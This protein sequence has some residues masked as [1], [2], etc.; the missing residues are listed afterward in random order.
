VNQLS[1]E[2][3]ETQDSSPKPRSSIARRSLRIRSAESALS[4]CSFHPDGSHTPES[5]EAAM[6]ELDAEL[7]LNP[8]DGVAHYQGR[9]SI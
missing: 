5:L 7:A 4:A 3:L 6:K 1:G 8:N 9:R 2:I